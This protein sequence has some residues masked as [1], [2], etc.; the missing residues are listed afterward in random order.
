MSNAYHAFM[1]QDATFLS[2]SIYLLLVCF[3]TLFKAYTL[4]INIDNAWTF[5]CSQ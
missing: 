2:S 5:M 1:Y 4:S 3:A